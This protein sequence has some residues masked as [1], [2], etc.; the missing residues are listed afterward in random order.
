MAMTCEAPRATPS[1]Q[2]PNSAR[3]RLKETSESQRTLRNSHAEK[4]NRSSTENGD[5]LTGLDS[6]EV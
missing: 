6:S 1:E 2:E 4:S 5:D 3:D